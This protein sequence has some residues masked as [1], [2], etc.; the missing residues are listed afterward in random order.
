MAV[1]TRDIA[2]DARSSAHAAH[3]RVDELVEDLSSL[4][5]MARDVAALK[6]YAKV[7]GAVGA[8]ALSAL[9]ALV[10][11]LGTRDMVPPT[12]PAGATAAEIAPR[13]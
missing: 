12:P 5:V 10:V 6:A 3:A 7:G 11:W 13:R 2:L 8:A 1:T 4:E 9:A